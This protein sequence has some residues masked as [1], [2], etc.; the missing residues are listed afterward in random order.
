MKD[1]E[2]TGMHSTPESI[3]EGTELQP[4][5]ADAEQ[6][7]YVVRD[8]RGCYWGKSKDWVDGRDP[9]QVARYRHHDEAVNTLFELSS[10]D[11]ALR[12]TVLSASLNAR[13]EPA[14][15]P[16]CLYTD[17]DTDTD[18]DAAALHLNAEPSPP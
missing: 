3:E 8:Q 17:T 15:A 5:A 2:D 16:G 7:V 6:R 4:G 10:K 18:T 12:G 9:R 11:V 13:G 1:T 14:L